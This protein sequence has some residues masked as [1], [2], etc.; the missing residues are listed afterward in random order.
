MRRTIFKW[1]TQGRE[2]YTRNACS[3]YSLFMIVQLQW[4]INFTNEYIIKACEEAEKDK[5]WYESWWAYFDKVYTWFIWKIDTIFNIKVKVKTVD[6]LSKEFEVLY[7]NGYAFWLWLM[8]TWNLYRSLRADWKIETH[9]VTN[10]DLDNYYKG[11]HNHVFI[12]AVKINTWIILDSLKWISGKPIKM[13][14]ETLRAS[15]KAWIYYRNARTLV[16]QDRLL[17]KHLKYYQRWI[18]IENI[19]KLS[20]KEQDVIARASKLR[21]FHK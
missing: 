14:I 19:E 13:S 4:W 15:V 5:A 21:V 7:N 9:E 18:N 20:K 10:I 12:K 2:R 11:G 6:I 1:Y 3:I 8:Y 16:M 17:E